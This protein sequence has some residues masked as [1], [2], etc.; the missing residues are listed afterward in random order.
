MRIVAGSLGG[1]NFKSPSGH[2]THPMSEKMRGA[3]FNS[4]T[5]ISGLTI[6]DPFAGSGALSFEAISRG[7]ASA[8]IIER[9]RSAQRII[10]ENIVSLGL[11][12]QASLVTA[13]AHGWLR[14]NR[15]TFDLI[16]L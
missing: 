3:L 10:Q 1:R 13:N 9:D 7:A 14:N 12:P 6:L 4:L 5:D 8:V 16:L 15:E 11:E 2:A